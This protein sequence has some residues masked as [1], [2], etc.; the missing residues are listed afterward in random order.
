MSG[1]CHRIFLTLLMVSGLTHVMGQTKN[2]QLQ[3]MQ[4]GDFQIQES[5]TSPGVKIH[6]LRMNSTRLN[7][8]MDI[9]CSSPVVLRGYVQDQDGV[10]IFGEFTGVLEMESHQLRSPVAST[11]TARFDPDGNLIW[12][13]SLK[14][15]FEDENRSTP[16]VEAV[17]V[18]EVPIEPPDPGGPGG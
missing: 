15:I 11:F 12:V 4:E 7:V 8:A 1:Y 6:Y 10:L 13:Q 9:Q 18:T 3:S 5:F 2:V 16:D 14:D 17:T